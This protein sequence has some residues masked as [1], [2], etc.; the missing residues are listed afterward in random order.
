MGERDTILAWIRLYIDELAIL[1][2]AC[3]GP[4]RAAAASELH[5]ARTIERAIATGE[6]LLDLAPVQAQGH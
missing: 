4:A 5:A 2:S 3:E 1:V 6:Y